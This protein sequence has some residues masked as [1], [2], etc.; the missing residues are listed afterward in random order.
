MHKKTDDSRKVNC[1]ACGFGNCVEFANAVSQGVNHVNNCIDYNHKVQIIEKT[2][3]AEKNDEIERVMV[4]VK[5][6]SE[7]R[8]QSTQ[9]M[10]KS[11]KEITDAIYEVSFGSSENAKSIE[12]IS[13]EIYSILDIAATAMTMIDSQ[14]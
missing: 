2:N 4:E 13:H 1:Y 11:V 12:K 14:G 10:K 5:S 7:E 9:V 3:L 8:Q 6:I